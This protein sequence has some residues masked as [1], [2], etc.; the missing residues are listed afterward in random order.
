MDNLM[1]TELNSDP[2]DN[3]ESF[4]YMNHDNQTKRS[5]E[6][7][8]SD[9]EENPI[10]KQPENKEAGWKTPEEPQPTTSNN[11]Y[12][13]IEENDVVLNHLIDGSANSNF[14]KPLKLTKALNKS[15]FHKYIIEDFLS[16]QSPQI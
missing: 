8:E 9:N 3:L 11:L 6:E 10:L 16:W 4:N 7:L 13:A 5:R 12:G 1:D 2:G 14:N 15:E